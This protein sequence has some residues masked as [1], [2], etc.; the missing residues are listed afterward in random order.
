MNIES[1]ISNGFVLSIYWINSIFWQRRLPNQIYWVWCFKI[2]PP[3]IH[4]AAVASIKNSMKIIKKWIFM[5][6]WLSYIVQG[7][8]S[9]TILIL[10]FFIHTVQRKIT[11]ILRWSLK[12]EY[13]LAVE[14]LPNK[15]YRELFDKARIQLALTLRL[16]LRK[17]IRITPTIT[18]KGQAE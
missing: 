10:W 16:P 8:H 3:Q 1:S 6:Y 7:E 15:I 9:T 13:Q 17:R 12:C 4:S 2:C 14:Y 18:K 5:P 11:N